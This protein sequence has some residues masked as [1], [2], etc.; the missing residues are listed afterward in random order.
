MFA[1]F[2]DDVTDANRE[3]MAN[4]KKE[5]LKVNL[6]VSFDRIWCFVINEN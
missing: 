3:V 6:F 5:M 1:P 2:V 4:F